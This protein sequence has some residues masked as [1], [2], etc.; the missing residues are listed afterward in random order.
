MSCTQI[1]YGIQKL[2]LFP[3]CKIGARTHRLKI[4]RRFAIRPVVYFCGEEDR[5]PDAPVSIRSH[6]QRVASSLSI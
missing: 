5:A 2:R 6:T 3:R 1:Q 4:S